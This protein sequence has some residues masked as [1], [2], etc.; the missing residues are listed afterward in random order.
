MPSHF[1]LCPSDGAR[2][3]GASFIGGYRLQARC[4]RCG[5]TVLLA[6]VAEAY[7]DHDWQLQPHPYKPQAQEA[8]P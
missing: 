5:A 6:H 7:G 1:G 2:L 4:P 8:R 3:V